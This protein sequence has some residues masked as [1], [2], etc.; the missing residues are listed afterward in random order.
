[1]RIRKLELTRVDMR[2]SEPYTIAYETISRTTNFFLRLETGDGTIGWG[3]AAPDLEVTGETPA[4]VEEGFE[5]VVFPALTGTDPTRIAYQLAK[6]KRTLAKQ[7]ALRA[8]VDMA[9]YDWMGRKAGMPLYRLLGGYRT[10]MRTAV[11]IG[12]L[13]PDET[14]ERAR[15]WILKGFRALKLKG[16]LSVEGDIER[17]RRVREAV[18]PRIELRFD[19]NQGFTVE[20]TLQ[21]FSS[22]RNE[23]LELIEQPTPK[24]KPDAMER[25]VRRIPIPVMADEALM[26]LG[27][28]FR[29]ARDGLADMV[30][31]KLM[32][33]GG[34]QE[35][36]HI[37]SVSVA[38]GLEVMVGCMDESGLG[39]AAG[40]HVALARPNVM[41]ADLDGH[42]DLL[43][44]PA[45]GAVRI[46]NGMLYPAEGPGLGFSF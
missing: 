19:A 32:K 18:G 16:G 9:L 3:C 10:R 7:P 27:D 37:N 39:I 41:Y 46:R 35:A 17:V 30:N 15:D 43:D 26:T 8:M 4:S 28:A 2:L 40:L 5:H 38:A 45:A 33:V 14:V 1:M 42:L 29:V 13:E 36:L 31:V 11:T 12:I 23:K 20:E 44:D 34:I 21:F 24:G 6:F 25:L 22:V